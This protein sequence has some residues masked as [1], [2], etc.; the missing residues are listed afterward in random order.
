MFTTN[1]SR[2]AVAAAFMIGALVASG[3]SSTDTD[4]AAVVQG[5]VIPRSFIDDFAQLESINGQE[6]QPITSDSG[7]D[8]N[9]ARGFLAQTLVRN[10]SQSGLRCQRPSASRSSRSSVLRCLFQ[11]PPMS[12][13]NESSSL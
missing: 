1:R 6:Q 8:A 11:M 7:Y 9:A 13:A 4:V 10:S 2:R 3:C 12:S 5:E